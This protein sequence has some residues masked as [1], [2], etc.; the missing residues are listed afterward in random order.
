VA[1]ECARELAAPATSQRQITP[2]GYSL[3]LIKLSRVFRHFEAPDE[4]GI[5]RHS[6]HSICSPTQFVFSVGKNVDH[7][8][9]SFCQFALNALRESKVRAALLGRVCG[10][11]RDPVTYRVDVQI[12]DCFRLRRPNRDP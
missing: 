10:L 7:S 4:V 1:V 11:L 9:T 6:A 2:P 8:L 3:D 12:R 5:A